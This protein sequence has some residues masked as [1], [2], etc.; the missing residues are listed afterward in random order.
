MS[1]VESMSTTERFLQYVAFDT[2]SVRE[3][4]TAPSAEKELALAAFLVD[5]LKALGVED[6][7]L[8]DPQDLSAV[9][10]ALKETTSAHDTLSVIVFKSPCRLIDRSKGVVPT[11]TE[12]RKCGVCIQIGCPALGKDDEGRAVIDRNQCIGCNQCVQS[13]PFGCIS[14]EG[15]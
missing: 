11:I 8:V 7:R 12:C 5:E 10:T 1:T 15:E 2:Q 9:R 13:C 14:K 3:S 4:T 6:V